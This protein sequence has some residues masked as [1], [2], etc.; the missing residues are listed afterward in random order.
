MRAF[1]KSSTQRCPAFGQ[2]MSPNGRVMSFLVGGKG[3][4]YFAQNGSKC[5]SIKIIC[6]PSVSY[7]ITFGLQLKATHLVSDKTRPL[8]LIYTLLQIPNRCSTH[9]AKVHRIMHFKALVIYPGKVLNSYLCFFRV[10]YQGLK[11][12]VHYQAEWT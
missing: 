10:D 5:S 4:F 12:M 6:M 1:P 11:D 9:R 3:I 2:K 8:S 7:R